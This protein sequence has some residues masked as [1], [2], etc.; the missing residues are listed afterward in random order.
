MDSARY[1]L[2]LLFFVWL[3]LIVNG[4]S[5][6]TQQLQNSN[7]TM[8]SQYKERYVYCLT[9]QT[10]V[11]GERAPEFVLGLDQRFIFTIQGGWVGKDGR[12]RRRFV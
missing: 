11:R 6:V 8:I 3:Y 10:S 4:S 5:V 7:S 2:E 12:K 1:Q 9:E